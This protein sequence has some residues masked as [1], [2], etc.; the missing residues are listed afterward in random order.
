LR[1]FKHND[2]GCEGSCCLKLENI[3][4]DMN[5]ARLLSDINLHLHCGEIAALIGPNGAGKSTL[6]KTILGQHPSGGSIVFRSAAGTRTHPLV[7]YV[8]QSPSFDPSDPVSVLDLFTSCVSRHPVFLP[9]GKKHR[10]RAVRCLS[11][12]HGEE[13]VDKRI[14]L[15]SGGELQ[16]VLLALALEPLPQI[17]ILDEPVSAVDITGISVLMEMLSEIRTS[18][19]LSILMTTHDFEVLEPYVDKVYLLNGTIVAS[20]TPSEVMQSE[21]FCEAFHLGRG[22]KA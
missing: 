14:G 22:G 9:V 12:V 5:G 13:L 20:G 21:A 11:R 16:R 4:V 10:E 8:P 3:N 17:L 6:L 1:D 15:L 7:G 19:D 18:Y 2:H